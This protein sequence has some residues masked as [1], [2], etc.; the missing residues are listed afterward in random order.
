MIKRTLFT[1]LIFL[2]IYTVFVRLVNPGLYVSQHQWQDNA[3]KAQNYVYEVSDTVDNVIVGS[4]LSSRL[5]MDSLP[6]YYN[7]SFGGL[8]IFNGLQILSRQQKPL[9]HVLIEMNVV[10]REEDR[11]FSSDLFDPLL[12]DLKKNILSLRNGKEPFG[13]IGQSLSYLVNKNAGKNSSQTAS[14]NNELFEKVL[15]NQVANYTRAQDMDSVTAIFHELKRYVA[16]LQQKGVQVTFFEMPVNQ[17]LC[18]LP[19]SMLIKNNFYRNFPP[20]QYSYIAQPDCS[21]YKTVDGI[22]LGYSEA[23]KYTLFLRTHIVSP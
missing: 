17:R 16:L 1:A 2:L 6:G 18:S 4:S 14:A 23:L 21:E 19:V 3:I 11:K 20:A 9:K 8:S 22:H 13:M 12:F 15:A 7:L 5:V 10:L